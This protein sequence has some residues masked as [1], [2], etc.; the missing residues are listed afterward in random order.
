MQWNWRRSKYEEKAESGGFC[1]HSDQFGSMERHDLRNQPRPIREK[2]G[3]GEVE[4]ERERERERRL[5]GERTGTVVACL[6]VR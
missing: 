6:R 4:R 3:D 5:E 2:E 1:G